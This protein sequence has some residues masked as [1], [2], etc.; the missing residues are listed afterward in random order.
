MFFPSNLGS[1]GHYVM[2]KIYYTKPEN[3]QKL[4]IEFGPGGY[5]DSG[6]SLKRANPEIDQHIALYLPSIITNN[7]TTKYGDVEMGTLLSILGKDGGAMEESIK[8][9]F[10]NKVSEKGGGEGRINDVL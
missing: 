5:G 10:M 2:F 3:T 4:S 8:K 6:L 9:A 7:Q 1:V